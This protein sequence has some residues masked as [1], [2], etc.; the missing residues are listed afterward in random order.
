MISRAVF[1]Q[2]NGENSVHSSTLLRLAPCRGV[3][4]GI[5]QSTVGV[6]KVRM[7]LVSDRSGSSKT[8]H[9]LNQENFPAIESLKDSIKT[10][11]YA[12]C[13]QF[14]LTCGSFSI[15][16]TVGP[17]ERILY[18]RNTA[19]HRI[20]AMCH[21]TVAYL[22]AVTLANIHLWNNFAVYSSFVASIHSCGKYLALQL[23]AP[24]CSPAEL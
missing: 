10:Q 15:D 8:L 21:L 23:N 4:T 16:I 5:Q 7:N 14:G 13:H 18:G 22:A 19:P 2:Q 17:Q 11:K 6:T 9:S 3:W 20:D 12:P 1:R 24:L